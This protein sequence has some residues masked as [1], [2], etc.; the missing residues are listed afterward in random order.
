MFLINLEQRHANCIRC[1]KLAKVKHQ[2]SV[3]VGRDV[4][5]VI[6]KLAR[7]RPRFAA[8]GHVTAGNLQVA[9]RMH[10]LLAA[11][12]L[13][14]GIFQNFLYNCSCVMASGVGLVMHFAN[15]SEQQ[16]SGQKM[17]ETNP[18]CGIGQIYTLSCRASTPL[19]WLLV[20][21]LK[22]LTLQT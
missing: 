11:S 21:T 19:V 2:L 22:G 18:I 6:A 1:K 12:L 17:F 20:F 7:G 13:C 8:E 3:A 5:L 15:S 14:L 16:I 10:H 4:G 9:C